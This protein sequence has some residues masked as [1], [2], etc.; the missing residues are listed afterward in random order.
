[1]PEL[2]LSLDA[3]TTST[4]AMLTD[5]S[6][7]VLA[8][9]RQPIPSSFPA[10]GRVEQDADAV[11]DACLHVV[12]AVLAKAG[13]KLDDVAALG[14]ATQ[15]ASIVI[16]DRATGRAAAPMIV[17]SDLRGAERAQQLVAAGFL[18]WPQVPSA[19]LESAL[20]G[21]SGKD[22]LWGTLDSWLLW[23][24]S[25]GAT[26][27][28]DFASAWFSGYADD[29]DPSRWNSALLEYQR[30]PP[31]IFPAIIDNWGQIATARALGDIPITA[32]LPDQ[33]AGMIAHGA[34]APG[35]WKLT[36]GTSAV[37]MMATGDRLATPHLTM[38]PSP[39]FR[40]GGSVGFCAE[41]MVISAGSFIEW[42]CGLG[43]FQSAAELEAL[44]AS[45]ADCG[46]VAVRPSLQGLGAPHGR[47]DALA[48]IAGL[49]GGAS[50]AHIARATMT[51]LACR[52]REIA[53]LLAGFEFTVPDALPADGGLSASDTMLQ[54]L[55]DLL[56]RPVRRHAVSEGSAFGAAMAAGIGAGLFDHAALASRLRYVREFTPNMSRDAAD[57][58]FTDWQ[59]KALNPA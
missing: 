36:C 57:A 3:G 32:L 38:L 45:V 49:T 1:M 22:L 39:L 17:W 18:S 44:A 52:M 55:A 29:T 41:G 37:V 26:H 59:A 9:E 43:L 5:A 11:F 16:W 4:R 51:A 13:R 28:T 56:G 14:L 24:L 31:A 6:G 15:R 7:V 21:A 54:L 23:K 20:A 50:R 12:H 47:F 58:I 19:K 2:L 48:M 33:Q 35:A 25:G 53:D 10:P 40:A 34:L 46:G 42:L 30:L 8:T 27:A